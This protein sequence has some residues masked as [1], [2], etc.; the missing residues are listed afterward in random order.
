MDQATCDALRRALVRVG[1]R[2]AVVVLAPRVRLIVT[3][4]LP[5]AAALLDDSLALEWEDA[6]QRREHLA[7]M[8]ALVE[9]W[10]ESGDIDAAVA[11][12][13]TAALCDPRV[14]S[15]E[16]LIAAAIESAALAHAIATTGMH[17]SEVAA[18]WERETVEAL[19]A[20]P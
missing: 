20:L 12:Q 14:V 11:V 17:D 7:R 10:M 3:K 19:L 1:A 5:E 13:Q 2:A 16:T 9:R 4:S 6:G 15:P 18:G 8:S